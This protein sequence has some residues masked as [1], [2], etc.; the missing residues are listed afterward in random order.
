MNH[1]EILLNSTNKFRGPQ[2]LV[3]FDKNILFVVAI[4]SIFPRVCIPI[5]GN[6][7]WIKPEEVIQ[8]MQYQTSK[9]S[10]R[11]ILIVSE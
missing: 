1:G 7:S 10:T 9:N 5:E 6:K 8:F 2:L 4:G 11:E 3:D